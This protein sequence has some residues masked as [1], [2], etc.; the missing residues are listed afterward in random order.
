MIISDPKLGLWLCQRGL[1]DCI[2]LHDEGSWQ[3]IGSI[4]IEKNER[5]NLEKHVSNFQDSAQDG[6]N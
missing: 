5:R 3:G 2:H 1:K 6:R 4:R